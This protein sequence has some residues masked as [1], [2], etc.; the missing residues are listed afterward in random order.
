MDLLLELNSEGQTIVMATHEQRLAE[1]G[2]HIINPN[3][4]K[5]RQDHLSTVNLF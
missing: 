3:N 4:G 5:I 1:M 2:T